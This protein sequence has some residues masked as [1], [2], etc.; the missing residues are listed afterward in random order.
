MVIRMIH[1][2]G[3]DHELIYGAGAFF[4]LNLSGAQAGM[5]PV[6]HVGQECVVA[7][8]DGPGKGLARRVLFK[9][10]QFERE[11]NLPDSRFVLSRVFFG[12]LESKVVLSKGDALKLPRYM[13]FFNRNGAFKRRSVV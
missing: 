8:Y 13:A 7:S 1:L 4:D 9:T 6:I 10:Y 5:L 3:R 12:R 11:E 2:D